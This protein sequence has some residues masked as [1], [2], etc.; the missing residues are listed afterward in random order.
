[1][2]CHEPKNLISKQLTNVV[3]DIESPSRKASSKKFNKNLSFFIGLFFFVLK[4]C[5][6]MFICNKII[7]KMNK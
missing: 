5:E 7:V 2:E 4:N 1:M 6:D 3:D